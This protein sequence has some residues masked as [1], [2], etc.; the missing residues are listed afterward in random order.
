MPWGMQRVKDEDKVEFEIP[1]DVKAKIEAGERAS[2]EVETLKTNLA[3]KDSDISKLREDMELLKERTQAATKPPKADDSEEETD[4]FADPRA[5]MDKA[6]GKNLLPV[7]N[8]VAEMRADRVMENLRRSYPEL[9]APNV[10]AEFEAATAKYKL[11]DKA[12]R[13]LME[14]TFRVVRDRLREEGKLE[15]AEY[16]NFM[17]RPR[18]GGGRLDS[19]EEAAKAKR[20]FS[21]DEKNFLARYGVTEDEASAYI[22][23]GVGSF[24][25]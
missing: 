8:V 22:K 3:S 24:G 7:V 14:N 2:Q 18:Q 9:D 23:E 25:R 10:S 13:Q 6:I 16:T 1:D 4:Y 20:N 12:N 11:G 21:A 15:T 19:Q 17:E 5:A